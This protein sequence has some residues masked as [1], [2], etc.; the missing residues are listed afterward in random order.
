MPQF[1]LFAADSLAVL[2]PR[3]LTP[4]WQPNS[5]AWLMR[6]TMGHW[7]ACLP[8]KAGSNGPGSTGHVARWH[9]AACGCSRGNSTEVIP[10]ARTSVP[11]MVA[12]GT[13]SCIDAKV[14]LEIRSTGSV[15][16][17]RTRFW[18]SCHV[19]ARAITPIP[20]TSSTSAAEPS[21]R[22]ARVTSDANEPNGSNGRL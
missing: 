20:L 10:S 12:S 1:D 9:Y 14:T 17:D 6:H 19:L 5:Q 22:E 15:E 4:P 2:P 7:R 13:A 18:S 11:P 16:S 3:S 21:A 8:S